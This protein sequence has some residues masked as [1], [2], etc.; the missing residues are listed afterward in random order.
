MSQPSCGRGVSFGPVVAP[1][2]PVTTTGPTIAPSGPVITT[3]VPAGSILVTRATPIAV[4]GGAAGGASG[5]SGGSAAPAAAPGSPGAAAPAPSATSP[6]AGTTPTP[7]PPAGLS[8]VSPFFIQPIALPAMPTIHEGTGFHQIRRTIVLPTS[9]PGSGKLQF[10]SV[11]CTTTTMLFE[12][13]AQKVPN[14]FGVGIPPLVTD[15]SKPIIYFHP[16]P[17]QANYKDSDYPTKTGKWPTLFYYMERLGC[18]LDAAMKFF[19][20]PRN[21]IVIMPFLTEGAHDTGIFAKEWLGIVTDILT[22]VRAAMSAT[23][24]D[25]GPVI[26]NEVVV[27]SFSAGLIYSD[28]FRKNG[29]ALKPFLKQIWDFDGFPKAG[30]DDALVPTATVKLAKYDQASDPVAL[31]V[32]LS[33]WSDYPDPP[34]IADRKKPKNFSDV[35]QLVPDCMFLHAATGR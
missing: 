33:R 8:H 24:G 13:E 15:F 14:W 6:P 2:G 4:S 30:F 3:T 31:H 11:D 9:V 7:L 27:A 5:A 10:Q 35:H 23:G 29:L 20:A 21:Q 12:L 32:P 16:T 34:N 19:G 28:A 22:D 17:A 1:N 18:Q 25:T 26:V